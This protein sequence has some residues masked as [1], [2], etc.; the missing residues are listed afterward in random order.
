[1]IPDVQAQL[2]HAHLE[3]LREEA[4]VHHLLGRRRSW[5][6]V[7]GVVLMRLAVKVEPDLAPDARLV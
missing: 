1:M 4:R 6:R 3:R 2:T 5:R 7:I